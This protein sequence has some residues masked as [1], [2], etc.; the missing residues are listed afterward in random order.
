MDDGADLVSEMHKHRTEL[1]ND[2]LGW[3]NSPAGDGK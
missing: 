3:C 2:M 1:I